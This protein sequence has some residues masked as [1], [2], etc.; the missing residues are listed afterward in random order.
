MTSTSR[1]DAGSRLILV[2]GRDLGRQWRSS[3]ATLPGIAFGLLPKV[4]CPACWPA[5]ASVF[6]S[7]G[8]GFLLDVRWLF[9]ATTAFLIMAVAA[10]GFRARRRRGFGPLLVGVGAAAIVLGGK[11][12]LG[13]DSA[14]YAGL[15]LLVGASIW[16]TWP[17]ISKKHYGCTQECVPH[18]LKIEQSR[19]LTAKRSDMMRRHLRNRPAR[20]RTSCSRCSEPTEIQ[21]R[22]SP[23][24]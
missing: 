12:A 17:G 23:G 15:P 19:T 24:A 4:T 5:Y 3:L 2:D 10:L 14:M 21:V 8:L 13:I 7:L 11:F 1:H 20:R 6:T 16:N 18:R 9:P 22:S